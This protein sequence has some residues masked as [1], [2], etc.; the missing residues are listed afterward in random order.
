MSW[1]CANGHTNDDDSRSSC[2]VLS[3]TQSRPAAPSTSAAA[4]FSWLVALFAGPLYPVA[5]LLAWAA[6]AVVSGGRMP[7][8]LETGRGLAMLLAGLVVFW[9]TL[10]LER[11]AGQ[12][13]GY[14]RCRDVF[15]VGA[16]VAG[17]VWLAAHMEEYGLPPGEVVGI[18]MAAPF[19]F[20]GVRRM[21]RVLDVVGTPVRPSNRPSN[22]PPWLDD[23]IEG[24][25]WRSAIVLGFFGGLLGF[26]LGRDA[27]VLSGLVLWFVT[28]VVIMAFR[29]GFAA[30]VRNGRAFGK[31]LLGAI[32]GGLVGNM[33][34][35][36]G[37]LIGAAVG[38]Y[39]V[40]LRGG[41]GRKS[42]RSL[43]G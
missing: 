9:T 36:A 22:R 41:I 2:Y 42:R 30:L 24:S 29:G 3:C 12:S 16:L 10:P 5:G 37:M 31:V 32:V 27:R 26:T 20:F 15:R 35:V 21:D 19:V 28:S 14:R 40:G 1:V 8:A 23:F 13:S 17:I 25:N 33:F 6:M 39:L 11:R 18:A 34:S 43:Y 38:G 4:W 7:G